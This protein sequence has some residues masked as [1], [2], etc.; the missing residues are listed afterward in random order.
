MTLESWR[1]R[2]RMVR[3]F[4]W[5]VFTVT[6]GPSEGLPILV[7]HGFPSSSRD[8]FPA[9]PSLA[10]RRRVVVHDHLGFGLSDKPAAYSYSLV[11][12]AEVAIAL[13]RSLGIERGHLLAHDYGTSVATELLARRER[14]LCP[15]DFA[16][17]TLCNGSVH[18][19]LAQLTP[20]QHL[21]RR[22]HLGP[23]FARLASHRVFVA[24]LRR[25]LGDPRS[26]STE[27]LDVMWEL[28]IRAVLSLS[29]PRDPPQPPSRLV[30]P[31]S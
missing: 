16:S 6:E 18:I 17:V 11:E 1:A 29:L 30:R 3:V 25:I 20:S 13:W 14:G 4:G 22:P 8:F 31:P 24:Q 28:M 21:L 12:Q 10:A 19:E 27:D 2:G 9:L 15:V 5:D 7:L 23:I 26:V